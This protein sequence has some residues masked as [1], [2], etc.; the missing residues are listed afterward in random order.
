M[1]W[2]HTFLLNGNSPMMFR[3]L[4]LFSLVAGC[5]LGQEK[6][7]TVVGAGLGGLTAAYRI[8]KLTGLHVDVYEA[9]ERAGGRVYTVRIGNSYEELGGKSILDGNEGKSIRALIDEM[10]LETECYV[11]NLAKRNCF[12]NGKVDWYYASLL[13]GPEPTQQNYERALEWKKNAKNLGE[14]LDRLFAGKELLRHTWEMRMRGWEGNDTRDL[15]VSYFE[16][17]W[18]SYTRNYHDCRANHVG[19]YTYEYVKGGNSLLIERLIGSLHGKVHYNHPLKEISRTSDGRI[20]LHFENAPV[21]ETDYLVLAIPCSTLRDVKIAK[22]LFPE[23]Q[24]R[25][26]DELQYGTNA[27]ILI[28]VNVKQKTTSSFSSTEN[29]LIWF[30]KDSGIMTFYYG[31]TPGCFNS[32]SP[33]EISAKIAIELDALKILYP[34]VT[35]NMDKAVGISWK[36]EKYSKGSYSSWGLG[37]YEIFNAMEEHLGEMVRTVFR[38]I[39]DK[40]F[41]AGEHAAIGDAST[42]DGAVES[43]ERTARM[44]TKCLKDEM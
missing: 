31:G 3:F 21:V 37:Q 19:T 1:G 6:K 24:K 18:K 8:Q 11:I 41:F 9:R 26:I 5:I 34:S 27:K 29:T 38:P 4:V 2:Y 13:D 12:Y 22:G 36:H 42:L 28:P 16:G 44:V 23:D 43:G 25:A 35:V 32:D 39:D 17:F 15:C 40:I 30:N 7:V 20:L 10:R 33:E 14:I